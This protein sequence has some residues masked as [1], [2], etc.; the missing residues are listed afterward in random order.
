MSTNDLDKSRKQW[1]FISQKTTLLRT[2]FTSTT[3]IG[4]REFEDRALSI[5]TS[6]D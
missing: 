6:L 2:N 5:C 4:K 1:I 3:Q